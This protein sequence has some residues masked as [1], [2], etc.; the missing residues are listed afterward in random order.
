MAGVAIAGLA[1][2]AYSAYS[3]QQSQN[4]SNNYNAIIANQNR[5]EAELQARRIEQSGDIEAKQHMLRVNQLIGS[6]KASFAGAGVAL[7]PGAT[8]ETVFSQ[9][10][11]FGTQD[12]L[13][14]RNNAAVNARN[15]RVA[16]AG[17]ANQATLL[18]ADNSSPFLAA[19]GTLLSGI[20][21]VA[22]MF[23]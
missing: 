6:Q 23:L 13:T 9:T 20:P 16:G 15:A 8:P 22:G 10:A 14:I 19:G 21:K 1:L 4:Y 3:Q 2:S 7:E 12:A 17:Y 18:Q 11:G 5:A